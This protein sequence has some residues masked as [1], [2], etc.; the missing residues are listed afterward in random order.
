MLR[1]EAS[2]ARCL[3]RRHDKARV[4]SEF[5]EL[6]MPRTLVMLRD[7][8]STVRCLLR[9]HDKATFGHRS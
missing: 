5:K 1:D 2:I 7:E 3:L 6:A 8:A 9:R 4:P